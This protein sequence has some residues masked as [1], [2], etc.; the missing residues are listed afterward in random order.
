VITSP[1]MDGSLF[2]TFDSAGNAWLPSEFDNT[3]VEFSASQLTSSGSKSPTVVL[4]DDG[5]GTSLYYP[6]ELAFD[7]NGNL[8]VPNYFSDTVVEYAKDQLTATGDPAPAVKLSSAIF[9]G[10]WGLAFNPKGNL[11][12]MNYRSGTITVFTEK[13]LKTS[14]APVPKVSL[15]GTQDGNFQITFGPPS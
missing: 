7:K 3:I 11:A 15:T 1:E 13:Q 9:N 2:V 14:G 12:I 6:E 10:P 8:W 5:S 4:S